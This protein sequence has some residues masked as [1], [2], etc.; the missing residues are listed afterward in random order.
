MGDRSRRK[1]SHSLKTR[2]RNPE[3]PIS[4]AKLRN[5]AAASKLA[6]AKACL[7]SYMIRKAKAVFSSSVRFISLIFLQTFTVEGNITDFLTVYCWA[8]KEFF[9]ILFFT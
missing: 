5:S 6:E 3:I 1:F 7:V 9:S 2:Y 8:E 4:L